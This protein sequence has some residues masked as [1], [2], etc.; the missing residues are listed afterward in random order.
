MFKDKMKKG[1]NDTYK[2]SKY[3]LKGEDTILN[4]QNIKVKIYRN[5]TKK[6]EEIGLE[7]YI[8]GV[9]A[10]EMPV[11]FDIEAL[12][13]QAVAA[14]TYVIAHM[15][16]FGGRPCKDSNGADICDTT[17]CQVF[18]S[19]DER[20]N[21]WEKSKAETYWNKLS[22]A[23]NETNGQVLTYESKLVYEPYYFAVSAG[24]TESSIDVFSKALPYLNSVESKGEEI[25]PKYKSSNIFTYKYIAD[26]IN[27]SYTKA[28]VNS[29]SIQKQISILSRNDSG[30]V[31][32]IRLGSV[33]ITGTEFRS[34]F[35]LNSANFSFKFNPK[36]VDISCVGYGHGVG[37]SQWGANVM[38]KQGKKYT[39]ILEH[40]YTGV[41]VEQINNIRFK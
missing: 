36:T 2:I 22:E 15:D 31:K 41:K 9:I 33:E 30:S 21:S 11:E 8:L 19:K 37:M 17:H 7:E 26:T 38:A 40:Y 1:K 25:A 5:K 18:M 24:K 23:V 29:K 3:S 16:E 10:G 4:K 35:G 20:I 14:R 27:A 28:K 6:I 34:L 13:A 39:E 12:K 32:K